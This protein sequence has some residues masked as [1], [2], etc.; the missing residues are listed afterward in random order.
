MSIDA[1]A[2]IGV[3]KEIWKLGPEGS[4]PPGT[5]APALSRVDGEAVVGAGSALSTYVWVAFGAE[6]PRRLR[7]EVPVEALSDGYREGHVDVDV[8]RLTP[9]PPGGSG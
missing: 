2:E 3:T 6:S 1:I 7:V 4:P 5:P 9:A 8:E